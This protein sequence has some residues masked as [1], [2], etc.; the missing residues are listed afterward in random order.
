MNIE[1]LL[2][3]TPGSACRVASFHSRKLSRSEWPLDFQVAIKI[4]VGTN[5]ARV[6]MCVHFEGEKANCRSLVCAVAL[7]Y[8][9]D[10]RAPWETQRAHLTRLTGTTV[11]FF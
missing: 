7:R 1:A 6:Y 2:R 3:G 9:L 8:H 11:L 5:S 4:A 10:T